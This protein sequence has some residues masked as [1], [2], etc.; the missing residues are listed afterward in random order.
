[1]AKTSTKKVVDSNTRYEGLGLRKNPFSGQILPTDR[2]VIAPFDPIKSKIESFIKAFLSNKASRGMVFIGDYGTGKTYHLKWMK[3]L[4]EQ[5]GDINA[6]TI[7]LETPGLEPYDLVRGVLNEVGEEQ[8]AKGI[9]NLLR[10]LV[11]SEIKELGQ[12]KYLAQFALEIE[13]KGKRASSR[14]HNPSQS[15]M[16]F[17]DAYYGTLK[18]E[19]LL[20]HRDF[21]QAF[22]KTGHLSREK[23]RD[24]YQQ[25][26]FG[27]RPL[28]VTN[29]V[30]VA[31]E[32]ASICFY[33]G[34][35]ALASWER[36]VIP[37]V[38]GQGAFPP[39]GEPGFL[40]AVVKILV[41]SGVE[42]LVLFLDEFEK[43]PLLETM[44]EREAKRYLDTVRMLMDKSWHELPF[45]WVLGS[46]EDAWEWV[47]K[48]NRALENRITK[49]TLPRT[50]DV[51]LA[52]YI[53]SEF[54]KL[55]RLQETEKELHPFPEN[56]LEIVPLALRRTPRNLVRLCDLILEAAADKSNIRLPISEKIITSVIEDVSLVAMPSRE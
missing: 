12:T 39:Q 50:D 56:F 55:T 38:G 53:I 25:K 42:Y 6:R 35:P 37:G 48:E 28:A 19:D 10:P 22:D 23:L 40:Q 31:K 49:V 17:S 34:A 13:A 24:H 21:L 4:F 11:V 32:L 26:I 7:Y 33:S 44:T 54:L 27:N 47:A 36:L 46:N 29:N 3:N 9:W 20:D 18:D 14:T 8:I 1:M 45:A 5:Y 15:L 30:A 16:V 43:V 41:Q 2:P 51:D 52:R